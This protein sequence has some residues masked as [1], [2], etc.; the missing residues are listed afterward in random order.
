MVIIYVCSLIWEQCR[1]AYIK[2]LPVVYNDVRDVLQ[3]KKRR[4]I[5][6]ISRDQIYTIER[7]PVP[8]YLRFMEMFD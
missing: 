7:E 8:Q 4:K 5:L 2:S 1:I 6:K 3:K